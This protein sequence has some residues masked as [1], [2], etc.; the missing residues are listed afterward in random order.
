MTDSPADPAPQSSA[1]HRRSRILERNVRTLVEHA[2][3]EE[4]SSPTADRVA[5]AIWRF[6]G[7]MNF[8][9]FH[10]VVFGVWFLL[11]LDLIPG[12]RDF[13][14]AFTILGTTAAIEAIFLATFVLMAQLQMA[15]KADKRNQLDL[16]VSLLAEQET[17]HILR[18]VAAMSERIGIEEAKNPEIRELLRELKPRE[19]LDRIDVHTEAINE[20]IREEKSGK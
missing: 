16:Q 12:V 14:P 18:L 9:Y 3:E 20:Q 5:T 1:P 4:R 15:E 13:D 7:T 2:A 19:V 11:D 6:A 8:V 10:V 17:T